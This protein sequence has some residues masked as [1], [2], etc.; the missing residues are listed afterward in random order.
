MKLTVLN[1]PNQNHRPPG[2]RP[3]V[4]VIHADAAISKDH[5]SSINWIMNPAADVSYHAIIGRD[6]SITQLVPDDRRAWHCGVS[7]YGGVHDVNDFSIG[8]C[9]SNLNDGAEL[10]TAQAIAQGVELVAAK[11]R[12]FGIG[13]DGIC[14]HEQIARPMGRKTDP[15]IQFPLQGFITAV[16]NRLSRP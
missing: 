6:G 2:V 9:F 1:S 11:M 7:S 8:I 16:R 15:G 3:R 4:I 13:L 5:R 12:Q 14:T 10:Y